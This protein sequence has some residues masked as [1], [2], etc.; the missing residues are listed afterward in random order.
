MTPPGEH[1]VEDRA[2]WLRKRCSVVITDMTHGG[3]ETPD[4]IGWAGTVSTLV[5][6]KTSVADFR[7]DALKSFRRYPDSGMGNQRYF[8]APKGM[9]KVTPEGWGLLEYDGRK[10]R[11]AFHP[12]RRYPGHGGELSLLL[13]AIKRIGQNPPP[14]VSVRCYSYETK[15]RATIGIA[16][17]EP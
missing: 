4:A 5:E 11:V 17:T 7:A 3:A 14:G 15:R 10:L 16:S 2:E 12:S 13:S 9:I 1:L 6:C 8:C